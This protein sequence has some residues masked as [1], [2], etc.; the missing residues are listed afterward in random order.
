M[1]EYIIGNIVKIGEDY[2]VLESNNIGYRINT[3]YNSI[4]QLENNRI[5]QKI[6][7]SLHTREDGMFLYGFSSEEE[8]EMFNLLLKVSKIGPKIAIGILSLLKTNTLKKAIINK[9]IETLSKAPGIGKKTAERMV[10]ELKDKI[11]D[12][13]IAIDEDDDLCEII[14]IDGCKEAIQGLM[15][16]GYSKFEV[17]KIVR[18]FEDEKM[19]VE[20]IIRESL[21]KLSKG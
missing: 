2:L 9:D 10:L 3:S 12:L 19:S 20:D 1:F 16:L 13:D 11:N 8:M 6:I 15:T 14:R 7:T 4:S 5:N 17:E 18:S 21:K